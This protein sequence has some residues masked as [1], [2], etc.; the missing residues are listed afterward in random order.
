VKN[1]GPSQTV[2]LTNTGTAP[3]AITNVAV[4]P[5]DFGIL[6]AQ[7]TCGSSLAAGSHCSIGVFF[8]PT[9]TGTRTGTLSVT[10]NAPGSPQTVTL[11]GMGV[12]QDFAVAPSGSPTATVAPGQTANYMIAVTPYGGFD[13]TVVLSCS[14]APA[15]SACSLSSSSVALNGST[16][17]SVTVTVTTAG[18]TASLAHPAGF[19]PASGTLAVWLAF[20][21]LSGLA[22]L[23]SD[24]RSRKRHGR[25][26]YGLAFLCLI[27][28]V[29]M[30]SSC[31]G[32]STGTASST[33]SST[34]PPASATPAGS[35]DLTVT[36]TFKTGSTTLTHA[37]KLTLV[38]Q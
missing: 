16:P 26:F 5:A 21:G 38:V 25:L 4:S 27:S 7:T 1:P 17:A 12:G 22:L 30:F 35:Y 32:G 24:G 14:G 34:P 36:G 33:S 20:C 29:I 18:S 6:S 10:D 8:D 31:G 13:Q 37:A 9:A 23:G 19:P 11:T 2:T 28:L 3:L 15:Q